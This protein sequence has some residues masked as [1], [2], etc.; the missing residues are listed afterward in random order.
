LYIVDLSDPTSP[1][2]AGSLKIPGYSAYLHPIGEGLLV[3]VGQDADLNGQVK[4]TQVALF[5][6]SD[7]NDP[8]Q[9]DKITFPGGYS[10]AEWDHHAFL[11]WQPTSTLVIPLTWGSTGAVAI[12]TSS[13]G[14]EEV[15]TIEQFNQIVRTVV[16]GGDRLL[17]LSYDGITELELST[18]A[19]LN[20]IQLS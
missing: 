18:L 16:V 17:A 1:Q 14:L 19:E 12:Q 7:P 11:Y 10:E 13:A 9:V 15:A 3:G 4:G 5:D 2:L 6:V 20:W 8:I